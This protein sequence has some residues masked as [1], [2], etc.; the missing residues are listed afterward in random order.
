MEYVNVL[1]R[2]WFCSGDSVGAFM[3]GHLEVQERLGTR[4]EEGSLCSE[5][6]WTEPSDQISVNSQA[7]L[8]T[9]CE[10][11]YTMSS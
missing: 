2:G 7:S 4:L 3:Q 1:P 5:C 9:Q 10:L 6:E 11:Q 8:C